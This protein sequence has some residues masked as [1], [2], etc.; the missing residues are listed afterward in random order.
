MLGTRAEDHETAKEGVT[1]WEGCLEEEMVDF[2]LRGKK[3]ESTRQGMDG[4]TRRQKEK[5][6]P[7]SIPW[8]R[9]LATGRS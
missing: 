2:C 7:K 4:K 5:C 8:P 1:T 3:E 6:L 9:V